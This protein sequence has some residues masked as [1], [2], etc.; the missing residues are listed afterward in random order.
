MHIQ[1]FPD[2]GQWI[3]AAN[4]RPPTPQDIGTSHAENTSQNVFEK[5]WTGEGWGGVAGAA[6]RFVTRDEAEAYLARNR[7]RMEQV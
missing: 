1:P 7:R 6:K 2:S 5:C 4:V 3:L